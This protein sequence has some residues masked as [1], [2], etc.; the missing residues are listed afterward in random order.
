MSEVRSIPLA[1]ILI[2]VENPRLPSPSGGQREAI[3]GIASEDEQA[4]RKLLVLATHIVHNGLS[5]TEHLWVMPF[6]GKEQR[7][8]VLEGNR[9]FA[10]LKGLENP[11]L[12]DSAI[13][14]ALLKDLRRLSKQYV[15][16]PIGDISCVVF[17]SREE[18]DPWIQL[19]HDGELG[20][21]GTVTW[22]SDEKSRYRARMGGIKQPTLEIQTQALN[23]L[24][25]HGD[26]TDIERRRV[27]A[28]SFKRLLETPIFREK[29][30]VELDDGK[31][32]A[33]ADE[34]SVAKALLYTA[35]ALI[36]KKI[37]TKDIYLIDDRT[38][39]ANGLPQDVAVT[40]TR[41]SGEGILL[42]TGI[43]IPKPRNRS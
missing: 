21:A 7:F 31:L 37:K 4:P 13:P 19:K 32:V 1:D 6:K 3:R 40:P 38:R 26:L 24:Q 12:F 10:A 25:N 16:S 36:S 22:G 11:D 42:A 28:T 29:V 41:K 35:R 20:G 30:G 18:A 2:D 34:D 33:L 9:R 15:E 8:V 5:P 39:I 43:P 14:P 27:P 23:F 17:K